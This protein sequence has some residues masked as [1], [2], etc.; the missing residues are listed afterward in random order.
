MTVET[1]NTS[2]LV[3]ALV[4]FA[5]IASVRMAT[6]TGM[7]A[8]L[9]YLLIG[10][11]L[12]QFGLAWGEGSGDYSFA[13]VLG[14]AALTVI[15]AE[16]GLTTNWAS[17]RPAMAPALILATAG[18]LLSV[19]VVAVGAHYLLGMAWQTSLLVGAIVSSTDAAAVFSV[20]RR[21]P[22][23]SRISGVLEAESGLNDAPVVILVVTLVGIASGHDRPSP[24]LVLWHMAS[25]L[26]GG[27]LIGV[28]I[29]VLGAR[30][31]RN[32]ALPASGLYPIA[33]LAL[34]GLSYGAA[35]SAGTSGFLAAYLA[36]LVLGNS[37]LPHAQ[38][39]RGFAEGLGWLAQIGL[40][41]L[42]GLLV[43]ITTLGKAVVPA[44]IIGTILLLAA[45]PISVLVALP[46]MEHR[47]RDWL[48][49]SWAGLRG[50]VPIILAT[51]PLAVHAPG[52]DGLFETIFVLV[53][54]FTLVQGPSLPWVARRMGLDSGGTV[55]LGLETSPLGAFDARVLQVRIG[56][57]SK[58]HGME[59]IELRLPAPAKVTLIVRDEET[60]VPAPAT[61][62]KRGDGL[63][64]VL[65]TSAL[66]ATE[67]RLRALHE[68][69]RLAQWRH[70]GPA[71]PAPR[72]RWP[73]RL[74]SA[75]PEPAPTSRRA[76]T[77]DAV[78]KRD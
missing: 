32:V 53:V 35:A 73:R 21:V 31:L 62:L 7:P 5:A 60:M 6:R 19:G 33:V 71:P 70:L 47:V 66:G 75:R 3:G 45:R 48:F 9:L 34:S 29:G 26:T 63:L 52:T 56:P 13:T 36:G 14:Y 74:R 10:V 42:L 2:V 24:W 69:G 39:V 57:E 67:A 18:T 43:D 25:E 68:G 37:D 77:T 50:A 59:I 64:V 76:G 17:I 11:V 16:G 65:P 49:L 4:L 61:R 30:L 46:W 44:L 20:L 58:L 23:P 51:I 22:L 12:G 15:L 78:R 8:L 28:A 1:L 27:A 54:I 72:L 40:F 41:V 55:D 38:A